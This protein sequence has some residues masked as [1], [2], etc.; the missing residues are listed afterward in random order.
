[1]AEA[2]TYSSLVSDVQLYA[3][4]YDQPFIAQIPRFIMLAENRLAS[5]IRGL[6][7]LRSVSFTMSIGDSVYEKPARWRETSSLSIT[8]ANERKYL[9]H[10]GYQY[11]RAYWPDSSLTAEPAFYS[12]YDYEHLLVVPTPDV[13]YVSELLYYERPIPLSENDQTNWTTRYAPQLLLYATLLEA[14]PFLKQTERMQQFQELY[15]RAKASIM[16]EQ[17]SK[18]SDNAN[19]R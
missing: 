6:G 18:L 3:E 5:E 13:A 8:T 14:Q 10:R 19:R 17:L 16:Q 2:L 15:E 7:F 4:R 9:F 1:M 11:N 12:D